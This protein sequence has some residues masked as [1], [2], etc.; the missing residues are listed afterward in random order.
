M[1]QAVSFVL[2]RTHLT[3]VD[4]VKSTRIGGYR[5]SF[6]FGFSSWLSATP[7]RLKIVLELKD[8]LWYLKAVVSMLVTFGQA[9]DDGRNWYRNWFQW[10][11]AS[12]IGLDLRDDEGGGARWLDLKAMEW[13]GD[14]NG[15]GIRLNCGE[16]FDFF[17]FSFFPF[18]VCFFFQ[19]KI[20]IGRQNWWR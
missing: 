19:N 18:F 1:R 3:G 4:I 10:W 9:N 15:D 12:L 8:D 5:V 14:V 20:K 11:R 7:I 13:C 16:S 2:T 17:S 6:G